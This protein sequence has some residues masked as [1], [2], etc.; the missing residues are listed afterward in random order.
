VAERSRV[1]VLE[2]GSCIKN[3]VRL[4]TVPLAKITSVIFGYS[5]GVTD[6]VKSNGK[7]LSASTASSVGMMDVIDKNSDGT[8]HRKTT[9]RIYFQR[10]AKS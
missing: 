6:V 10:K 3:R 8:I 7:T 1:Q 9:G 4:R 5:H 2:T